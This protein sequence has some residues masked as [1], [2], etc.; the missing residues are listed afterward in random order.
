MERIATDAEWKVFR[1]E[2]R[3]RWRQLTDSQLDAI[4]GMRLR[5]AEQIC[6]TYGVPSD[7]AEREIRHFE[8]HNR[9]LRAGSSF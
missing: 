2:V 4:A 7:E 3:A 5:L 6:A 9:C 8:A 1:N